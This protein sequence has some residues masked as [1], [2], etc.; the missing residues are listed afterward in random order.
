MSTNRFWS[1]NSIEPKRAFRWLVY[2]SGAPQ[3]IAKSVKKPGFNVSETPHDYLNYKFYY[4]GRVDWTPVEL[5]I[6][7]PVQPD[8][9]ASLIR[10]LQN[11]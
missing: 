11:A 3:F 2:I 10:I 7:D 4:P 5:T 9:T 8:S 6:V 1:E